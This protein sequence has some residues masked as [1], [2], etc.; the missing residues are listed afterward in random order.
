MAGYSGT[1]LAKKLGIKPGQ[2]IA[3]VGGPEDYRDL[4][5]ELPPD[6]TWSR[7]VAGTLDLI[8]LFARSRGDLEPAFAQALA[9][10]APAGALWVSWPKR[11]SRVATDL[12]ENVVRGIGLALGVVDVKVC[13]VDE[14]WSGL[15]FVRRLKDRPDGRRPAMPLP[16]R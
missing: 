8:Q 6:V 12:D 7:E 3:V 1:P 5:G 15:K 13:A 11:S 10:L 9:H 2:I 4:L 14:T 16:A